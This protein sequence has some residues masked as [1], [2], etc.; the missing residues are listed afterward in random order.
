MRSRE[1]DSSPR[2]RE[3]LRQIREEL[4]SRIDAANRNIRDLTGHLL[5]GQDEGRRRIA[6][7]LHDSV[8]PSMAADLERLTKTSKAIAD[9]ATLVKETKGKLAAG[10]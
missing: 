10:F 9:S 3:K 8:G 2:N 7:E 1:S 4:E 5:H 6:R